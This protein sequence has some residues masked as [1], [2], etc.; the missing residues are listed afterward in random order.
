[1]DVVSYAR[2]RQI[3]PGIPLNSLKQY[4]NLVEKMLEENC[5]GW[6][7]V[8][9]TI[10]PVVNA[11][12][13]PKINIQCESNSTPSSPPPGPLNLTM[14]R[15]KSRDDSYLDQHHRAQNHLHTQRYTYQNEFIQQPLISQ[16]KE[17]CQIR[18]ASIPP[19]IVGKEFSSCLCG[20]TESPSL[21][22]TDVTLSSTN[23]HH[24]NLSTNIVNIQEQRRCL[25]ESKLLSPELD[26]FSPFINSSGVN[27]EDNASSNSILK[28]CFPVITDQASEMG[29]QSFKIQT[30]MEKL[31]FKDNFEDILQITT[32]KLKQSK[33][34]T[35]TNSIVE[36][37]N[38][39]KNHPV[40]KER[41]NSQVSIIS[42][43]Q[44]MQRPYTCCSECCDISSCSCSSNS[45]NCT[46][47]GSDVKNNDIPL[48]TQQNSH[49]QKISVYVMKDCCLTRGCFVELQVAF[50]SQVVDIIRTILGYAYSI[51]NKSLKSSKR[52]SKISKDKRFD[53]RC[54]SLLV[55][56]SSNVKH[57][58]KNFQIEHLQSPWNVG[59]FCLEYKN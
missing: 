29:K 19:C 56:Y 52:K 2:D 58:N 35:K 33:L 49:W 17:L 27:S 24:T 46:I 26:R 54:Y 10:F 1:M 4:L 21:I 55:I 25:S 53:D 11:Y 38:K 9:P 15:R 16:E 39:L 43:Q 59:Q 8:P 32:L 3:S 47:S 34:S 50:G 48:I 36:C 44:K 18:S 45:S 14:C 37:S 5:F 13:V 12:F 57:L 28:E 30:K 42:I 6:F 40:D 41:I 7:T 20:Q 23:L 22:N 51:K 31:F